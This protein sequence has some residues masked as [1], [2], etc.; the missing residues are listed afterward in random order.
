MKGYVGL[1]EYELKHLCH[2]Q[3]INASCKKMEKLKK[4]KKLIS[5]FDLKTSCKFKW[6]SIIILFTRDKYGLEKERL[7]IW[8]AGNLRRRWT[9]VPEP[10][11]N[12]LLGHASF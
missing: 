2:N 11:P 10:I 1:F 4:I 12:I 5:S 8:E 9:H 7:F 3:L 6:A